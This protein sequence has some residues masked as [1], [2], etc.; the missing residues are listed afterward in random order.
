MLL[1]DVMPVNN[2]DVLS[3]MCNLKTTTKQTHVKPSKLKGKKL[4]NGD[5]TQK[6]IIWSSCGKMATK[7][8]TFWQNLQ[9]IKVV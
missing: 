6:C 9:I 3:K 2:F 5:G 1:C 4:G 8:A 7:R